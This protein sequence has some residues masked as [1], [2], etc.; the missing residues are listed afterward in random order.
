MWGAFGISRLNECQILMSAISHDNERIEVT[1]QNLKY[2][3]ITHFNTMCCTVTQ[4]HTMQHTQGI[5]ALIHSLI[6]S[7]AVWWWW[8]SCTMTPTPAG[9]LD[10][11]PLSNLFLSSPPSLHYL[12]HSSPP[13]W[14]PLHPGDFMSVHNCPI[15]PDLLPFYSYSVCF[16]S[17]GS[18]CLTLF[19]LS[20][21]TLIFF[22]FH[23]IFLYQT[24]FCLIS[25]VICLSVLSLRDSSFLSLDETSSQTLLL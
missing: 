2:R 12:L 5:G 14:P 13:L 4:C 22:F 23:H 3:N 10:E 8:C 1:E 25:A 16:I 24:S 9:H 21:L 20:P 19:F 6:Q 15:S 17:P 11:F 7:A 18:F